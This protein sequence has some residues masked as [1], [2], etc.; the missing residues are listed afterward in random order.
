[1]MHLV[2]GV[3][4]LV[5]PMQYRFMCVTNEHP[6]PKFMYRLFLTQVGVKVSISFS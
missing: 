4:R 3:V 6:K 1:M 5:D 2:R